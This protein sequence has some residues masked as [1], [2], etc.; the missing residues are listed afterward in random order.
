MSSLIPVIITT[1]VT[2]SIGYKFGKDLERDR[3]DRRI[4]E[5]LRNTQLVIPEKEVRDIKYYLKG[6]K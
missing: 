3:S 2:F 1:I 4:D 6:Y 5:Y